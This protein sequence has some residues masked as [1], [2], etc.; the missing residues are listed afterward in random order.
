MIGCLAAR[1]HGELELVI[2]HCNF[3]GICS[4]ALEDKEK[5][6]R[7]VFGLHVPLFFL[8]LYSWSFS[9]VKGFAKH[10]LQDRKDPV[11][12]IMLSRRLCGAALMLLLVCSCF[13]SCFYFI[14]F[15]LSFI[16]VCVFANKQNTSKTTLILPPGTKTNKQTLDNYFLME[17]RKK[18]RKPITVIKMG[19]ILP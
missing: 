16:I 15:H 7:L 4:V 8:S 5:A 19:D 17:D 2:F 13:S 9:A 3:W 18:E 12:N 11:Q 14:F 6:T 10:I 1:N